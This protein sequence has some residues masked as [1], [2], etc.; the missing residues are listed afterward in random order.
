MEERRRP[1]EV[2]DWA[3]RNGRAPWAYCASSKTH[4]G[5]NSSERKVLLLFDGL[6]K[7]LS[8]RAMGPSWAPITGWGGHARRIILTNSAFLSSVRGSSSAF[9]VFFIFRQPPLLTPTKH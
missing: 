5:Y 6:A 8:G 1:R 7:A 4:S 9:R 2:L 3:I